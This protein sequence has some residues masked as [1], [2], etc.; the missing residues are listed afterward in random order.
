MLD[1]NVTVRGAAPLRLTTFVDMASDTLAVVGTPTLQSSG[2]PLLAPA[3]AF[4]YPPHAYT[5]CRDWTSP[6]AHN[7]TVLASNATSLV[8]LR[9][10]EYDA[11]QVACTLLNLTARRVSKHEFV[12]EPRAGAAS[13][14]L[15]CR[16]GA[17]EAAPVALPDPVLEMA[18][19]TRHA[20]DA[21]WQDGAWVDLSRA[22]LHSADAFELERRMI[23][24]LYTLRAHEYGELPPQESGFVLNTWYGKHHQVCQ[25]WSGRER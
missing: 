20:W 16:Y 1:T 24:S 11:H 22:V 5:G 6:D 13:W 2:L 4:P 7:T 10:F 21:F 19:R 25:V 23:L 18:Q 12:F 8:L 15:A 14:T 3:V 9:Q 17:P